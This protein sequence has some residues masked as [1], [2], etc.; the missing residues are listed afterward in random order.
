M[1][2]PVQPVPSN[3][4]A[5]N[6][7]REVIVLSHS[8]LFYWWPVWVVGFL[9]AAL[10]YWQGYQVAFVPRGT[11]A[12]RGMEVKGVRG[13]RDVLIAPA[14]RALPADSASDELAQPRLWMT[15]SNN[16]GI[17]W[18]VTFF[19]VI[20][21]THVTLRGIWSVVVILVIGFGSV[22]LAVFGLWDTISR[23]VQL[24]DI[25]FTAF[26]YLLISLFLFVIWLVTFLYLDRL[27]YMIFTR[28]RVRVRKVIGEG[29]KVYDTRG[30]V[31]QR[32]RDDFFRHWLL[33]FG[34][35]D[36]TVLTT[37]AAAQTI[38][39]PNVFGIRR[40]LALINTMLQELEVVPGR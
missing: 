8:P 5:D 37:G 7:P 1:S 27:Q 35:A 31:F 6:R 28:G 23:A 40:K 25:H 18:A 32:H 34:S 4:A 16:P 12:E 9:M 36:L 19:L 13:P 10:S 15:Q 24:L 39:M 2:N 11:K 14:G 29:E 30:M 20:L 3:A 26:S 22:L 17:L 21:I 38:E 33:G